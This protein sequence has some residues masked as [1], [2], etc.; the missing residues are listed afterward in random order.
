MTVTIKPD[1]WGERDISRKTIARGMPGVSGVTVVTIS[2]AFYFLHAGLRRV[3]RP[4]FPAPSEFQMRFMTG[5]TRAGAARSRRCVFVIA[6]RK[7]LRMVVGWVEHLRN[8]S[9]CRTTSANDGEEPRRCD[10][11]RCAPPILR[12]VTWVASLALA[13]VCWRCGMRSWVGTVRN[14]VSYDRRHRGSP[15]M[16]LTA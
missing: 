4:A 1:H 3:E 12:A 16:F 7:A 5:K 14:G 8:P 10:G 2:C 13:I 6:R 9:P 11:Y 15:P